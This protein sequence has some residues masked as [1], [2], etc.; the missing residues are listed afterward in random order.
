MKS[1][2][3]QP[4]DEG[5][6]RSSETWR[7]DHFRPNQGEMQLIGQVNSHRRFV[8][9]GDALLRIGALRTRIQS[10]NFHGAN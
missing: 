10:I 8:N 5:T 2:P 7:F 4:K 6:F 1:K 3:T 9:G